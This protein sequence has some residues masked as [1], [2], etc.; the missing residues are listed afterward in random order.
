MAASEK[1]LMDFTSAW[2]FELKPV[3]VKAYIIFVGPGPGFGGSS[4][5]SCQLPFS[6]SFSHLTETQPLNPNM[7]NSLGKA[8][9]PK[10]SKLKPYPR[11]PNPTP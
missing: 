3:R 4:H 2:G 8:Y 5:K 1:D 11:N 7:L 9:K 6:Y 10:W